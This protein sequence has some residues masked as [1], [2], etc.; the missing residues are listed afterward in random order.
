V[1]GIIRAA[2]QC[3]RFRVSDAGKRRS[4]ERFGWPRRAFAR[5][6]RWRRRVRIQQ[7]TVRC[8]PEAEPGRRCDRRPAAGAMSV[9]AT[10]TVA[11]IGVRFVTSG[12]GQLRPDLGGGR[13]RTHRGLVIGHGSASGFGGRG[14]RMASMDAVGGCTGRHKRDQYGCQRNGQSRYCRPE[15]HGRFLHR[16]PAS[17][18]AFFGTKPQI[19][20]SG[21]VFTM[22][23][24]V[25]LQRTR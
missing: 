16:C 17:R 11:A 6:P 10:A 15:G 9:A 25:L 23:V 12:N 7:Q 1:N 8:V 18:K 21:R 14:M 3:S 2:D 5:E 4:G 22:N 24:F 19:W 20:R 13:V